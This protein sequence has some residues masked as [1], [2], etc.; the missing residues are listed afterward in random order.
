MVSIIYNFLLLTAVV[1]A[2]LA[3]Q[4]KRK[5]T[6]Y[7]A[8]FALVSFLGV[9]LALVLCENV[10]GAMRLMCYGIFGH[11]ILFLLG[12][13]IP[14]W[15]RSRLLSVAAVMS[16]GILAAIA[17]DAFLIE[18]TWLQVTHHVLSS[19]KLTEPLRIVVIA[20]LQ[21]DHI[22]EYERNALRQALAE[23]P[24]MIVM[25]GDYLQIYG[26]P[27]RTERLIGELRRMLEELDFQAPLGV[28][29]VGGNT[30]I[31]GWQAIFSAGHVTI[32]DSTQT[33][34]CPR[35]DVCLTGLSVEDSRSVQLQVDSTE[36]FQI[37]L[38]HYPNFAL[39]HV[40]AD[41]LIAGHTHGGQIQLPVLGPILT[42]C[43]V[44][45]SWAAGLTELSDNRH[46]IVSRG[47]GMERGAAPRIRFLCRPELVVLDIFPE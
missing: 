41:L 28:Y 38:G 44:P 18:P 31:A 4:G 29:A 22:G 5:A 34:E 10:F 7:L 8:M 13:A 9:F 46:L 19:D 42:L 16:A 27:E 47:I 35:D 6:A 24:D 17:I 23:K 15:R 40:E 1:G 21:T 39:G 11:G 2:L 20:D 25:A 45:R 12:V 3:L 32:I 30:D 36:R 43:Q 26:D 37:C 14:I 33:I